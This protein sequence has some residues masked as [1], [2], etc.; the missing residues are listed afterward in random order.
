MCMYTY[1]YM[2]MYMYLTFPFTVLA[3]RYEK[4]GR[5]TVR[6]LGLAWLGLA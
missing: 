2:Y 5:V 1:M 6:M 4:V 3:A